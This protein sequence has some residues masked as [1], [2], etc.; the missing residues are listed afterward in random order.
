[1]FGLFKGYADDAKRVGLIEAC[2]GEDAI[3]PFIAPK[4]AAELMPGERIKY[5][6]A[7][8]AINVVV[9][10]EELGVSVR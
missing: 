7:K 3:V 10:K 6:E 4:G 5:D 9:D 1:M 8:R 2:S